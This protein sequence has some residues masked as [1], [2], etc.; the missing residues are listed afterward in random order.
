LRRHR[1]RE[2]VHDLLGEPEGGL[3]ALAAA[4]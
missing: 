2:D 1:A 4:R 3:A